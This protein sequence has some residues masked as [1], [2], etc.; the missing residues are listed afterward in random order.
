M[1]RV[2]PLTAKQVLGRLDPGRYADGDGLY[3]RVEPS[4]TRS[5][6]LI[7]S[8]GGRGTNKRSELGLGSA[9]D[10]S[11]AEAREIAARMRAA[12]RRGED[13][14]AVRGPTKAE[15]FGSVA[16]AYIEA[17]SPGWRNPKHV[18]QWRMTLGD[19]YC[20]AIRSRPV[21]EIGT[22]DVLAVLTPIWSQIPETAARLRGRIEAVLD[23]AAA[24]GLRAGDNP[25]RW[26]GHL[27]KLLPARQRLSRGHHAA[28]PWPDVPEFVAEL[29]QRD[30][31]S[32]LCLEFVILTACRTG[33]AIGARWDE[34]SGDVWT[35][36]AA[37]MKT[38]R[39]HRVP[40]SPRALA[41]LDT[42]RPIGG[43]WVFPGAKAD[44]PLSN[45][46][47]L[48]L[49]RPRG[50][51]VHGFRSSFRDWA[52]EAT[53][54]PGEVVEMCLAHTIASRVEA[55]YRRGD[56]LERR[57]E[58]MLAW[59]RYVCGAGNVLQLVRA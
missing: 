7:Y 26:R 28:L 32:A 36:P 8:R 10:V 19:A 35:V 52:A 43:Q 54:F 16:D 21:A 27:A 9:R 17:M 20:R 37:R 56:M 1:P 38:K 51:T 55:A 58:V 14:R 31:M 33:E 5:W 30:A 41:I 46:A 48:K 40:L 25:A 15:T 11:L 4:G 39:P 59:E 13:P 2:R 45:M 29:R 47:M 53:S 12:I 34:I 3:L 50:I 22:A 44:R 57:R 42:I 18:A 6:V 24:R 23:A 49:V